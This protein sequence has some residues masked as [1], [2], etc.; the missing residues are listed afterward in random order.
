MTSRLKFTPGNHR[1]ALLDEASGKWI[2]VPSV[3]TLLNLMAKPALTKWAARE[4]AS[5][6]VD[7][8]DELAL[9]PPSTRLARIAAAPDTRRNRKA[10]TGTQ[11]HAWAER[12]LA[13]EP[14][15]IPDELVGPV[16]GLAD[17]WEK[18]RC[19]RLQAEARVWSD[20]DP[21]LGLCAYAGTLDLLVK[22]PTR[23]IGLVDLKTGAGVYDDFAVQIAAYAAADWMAL[24]DDHPMPRVDWLGVLHVQPDRTDL[25]TV[26]PDSRAAAT[27]RFEILRALHVLDRP[28]LTLEATA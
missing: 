6:A 1:Y 12:L 14:L 9:E 21:D 2:Y 22:H 7:T 5:F 25:H 19:I 17:W 26:P 28:A 20:E 23:G 4:A 15:E 10:A 24:D 16:R 3:T 18:S 11:I 8:W 27:Q 13:G